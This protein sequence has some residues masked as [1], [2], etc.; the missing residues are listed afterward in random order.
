MKIRKPVSVLL[1]VVSL[2]ALTVL[3]VLAQGSEEPPAAQPWVEILQKVILLVLQLAIPP[4]L[5]WGIA[6][7]KQWREAQAQDSWI[8]ILEGVVRDAVAAAEQLGLTDQ[9]QQF[10]ESKL[11]YAIHYV[12]EALAMRGVPLDL[13]AYADAIRGMIEA[14]V[15]RQFPKEQATSFQLG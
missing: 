1:L 15:R 12:E 14:E 8:W 10:A 3:P 9:L 13:D 4:L 11:A 6:Q 2:L 5:A 7:F